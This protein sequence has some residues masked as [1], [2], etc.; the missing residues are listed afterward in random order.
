M[1]GDGSD[2]F[3]DRKVSFQGIGH[4]IPKID[5][6]FITAFSYDTDAVVV[7]INI[8]NIQAHTFGDTDAGAQKKG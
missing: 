1:T 5:D 3:P 8:L 7:K 4:F 6:G 2:P